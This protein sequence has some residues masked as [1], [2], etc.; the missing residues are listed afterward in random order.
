VDSGGFDQLVAGKSTYQIRSVVQSDE[1]YAA[2]MGLEMV[3]GSFYTAEDVTSGARR[4]VISASLAE[5]LFGSADAAVGQTLQ[6]PSPTGMTGSVTSRAGTT[7]IQRAFVMPTFTIVGVFKDVGELQ[8]TSYG[9]GDMILPSTSQFPQGINI[10]V[11]RMFAAS[12]IAVR[13]RGS[14]VATVEAQVREILTRQYGSDLK[15]QVWEGTPRG[16]TSAI[17]EARSTVSAFTLVV[18]LLGFILLVTGSIG[19]LSIMLVE[20]L[21]RHR[22]IA[23]ERA[24]GASGRIIVREYFARSLIMAGLSAVIGV[25]LGVVFAGPLRELVL[26]IFNGVKA[27]DIGTQIITPGAVGIGVASALLVGGV[28]GVFPVIPALRTGIAEGMRDT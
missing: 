8:R 19:I 11:A 3:A 26:P 17:R 22:Q 4:A 20:V 7:F 1:G 23:I 21:G 25:V 16:E 28:F 10:Q 12:T 27:A 24:L 6:P 9:V 13:V 2:V 18:N 15:L 5:I 14:G